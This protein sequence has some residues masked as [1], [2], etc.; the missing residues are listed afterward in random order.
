MPPS[1]TNHHFVYGTDKSVAV[2]KVSRITASK[3][4]DI[5]W[6]GDKSESV[7]VGLNSELYE[8]FDSIQSLQFSPK[9]VLWYDAK[10]GDSSYRGIKAEALGPF[11]SMSRPV[12][13]TI[14]K[15]IL[16]CRT[17]RNNH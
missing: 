12:Y 10:R 11:S 2:N 3:G 4:D 14:A 5:A 15:D 17:R 6:Q 1:Q 9:D 13:S 8:G 7:H 16:F